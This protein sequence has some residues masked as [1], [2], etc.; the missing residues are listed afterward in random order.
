MKEEHV[1]AIIYMLN[2]TVSYIIMQGTVEVSTIVRRSRARKSDSRVNVRNIMSYQ[3]ALINRLLTCADDQPWRHLNVVQAAIR[4]GKAL[5]LT[6]VGSQSGTLLDIL[7]SEHTFATTS[8][9]LE[10]GYIGALGHL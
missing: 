8:Y 6:T 3:V 4:T 9:T 1:T 5:M 2:D 10:V 7:L